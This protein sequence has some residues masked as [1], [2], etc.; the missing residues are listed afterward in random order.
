MGVKT[1][2]LVNDDFWLLGGYIV[3]LNNPSATL[4]LNVL[5]VLLTMK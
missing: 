3:I 1:Q 4:R 5:L 2:Y